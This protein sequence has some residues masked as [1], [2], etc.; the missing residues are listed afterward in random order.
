MKKR[1]VE[2]FFKEGCYIEEWLNDASEPAISIARV[3]VAGKQSTR[4]H[5]LSGTSERYVILNGKARVTVGQQ[6]W[7]V[8]SK[9]VVSISPDQTQMITN[10]LAEDLVFLAICCP[11]FEEQNYLDLEAE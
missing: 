8:T 2:Y 3:R 9:D 11:R 5:K 1:P 10:L 7:E 6:S 4:L